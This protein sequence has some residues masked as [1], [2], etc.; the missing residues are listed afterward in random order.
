MRH[1]GID[2]DLYYLKIEFSRQHKGKDARPL[3][4]PE[5][6]FEEKSGGNLQGV[7]KAFDDLLYC[8][9]GGV[10]FTDIEADEDRKNLEAAFVNGTLFPCVGVIF[11]KWGATLGWAGQPKDG[12]DNE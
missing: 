12:G 11:A 3:G 9:T 2:F 4:L 8:R 6:Y 1:D 7:C 10:S 5:K